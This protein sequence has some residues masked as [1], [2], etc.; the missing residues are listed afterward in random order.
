[1]SDSASSATQ[2]V[3]RALDDRLAR[4]QR[5]TMTVLVITQI[6]GTLGMGVAPTIGVLIA[7][8]VT[9]NE[10][11]AGLARTSSTLGAALLGLPLGILAAKMGRRVALAS[12]WWLAAL[13][14]GILVFASHYLE[15]V[16]LFIGLLLLGAGNAA[17]LQSRFT[18]TD[19]AEPRN[20][21]KS[22][23]LVV[24]V[25]TIGSVVGPN[26]G[27]PGQVVSD[28]TGLSVYAGTFLIGAVFLAIAGVIVFLVM[29][30]DPLLTLQEVTPAA[31]PKVPGRKRGTI[32]RAFAE[33]RTNKPARI[34]VIAILTAQIVMVSIM[35]MTPVHIM[36]LESGSVNQVGITISLHVLG[37]FA[38]APLVGWVVDRFG[39]RLAMW[40]GI[41]IFMLS[42]IAGAM[43]PNDLVWILVSLFLLGL[44][45]S[46]T[47]IAGSTL[48]ASTVA[49][50]ARAS[51]QGGIDALANLCGATAAFLAGPLLVISSFATLSVLA[52][53][54][55]VPL[56]VV[57]VRRIPAAQFA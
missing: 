30:P 56:S 24:W 2:T 17:S 4:V 19:L 48:F 34:A 52:M 32:R 12:G 5:R 39:S 44:G 25:G 45:W 13:G 9:Q 41:G 47:N 54:V 40:A 7:S 3:D 28:A 50:E 16:T 6:I 10:A 35:T 36:H 11:W 8:E 1:M 21:A 37:M 18:A 15:I 23:S 33:L 51:S 31:A 29:R 49:D 55:L 26:L 42:L 27:V 22:L 46:F 38:F 14:T 57:I 20:R 53:F 43:W